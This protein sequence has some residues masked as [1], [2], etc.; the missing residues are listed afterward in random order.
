[1]VT[2]V[3]TGNNIITPSLVQELIRYYKGADRVAAVIADGTSVDTI[4]R[5]S[6]GAIDN[7]GPGVQ[8][9]IYGVAVRAFGQERVVDIVTRV[10][11]PRQ[12]QAPEDVGLPRLKLCCGSP[13][14][15][16]SGEPH[17]GCHQQKPATKTY[18][19][20]SVK[21]AKEGGLMRVCK[22][23]FNKF[24]S[25]QAKL[26]GAAQPVKARASR[27]N[28][29]N[30]NGPVIRYPILGLSPLLTTDVEVEH[31]SSPKLAQ[32]QNATAPT[33]AQS[34]LSDR[35]LGWATEI[36]DLEERA[37]RADE[38]QAQVDNFAAEHVELLLLRSQR[39]QWEKD[40]RAL[41]ELKRILEGLHGS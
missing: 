27:T 4:L 5:A 32:E 38:L 35:I 23:C 10:P 25:S 2:D 29:E 7:I 33:N 34:D 15:H 31:N 24:P 16:E 1:M 41:S 11:G 9:K 17:G 30:R 40:A 39:D 8:N 37:R 21:F 22:E 36:A 14:N 13:A 20:A 26:S 6:G 3:Q 28:V 19:F 12:L 18:F